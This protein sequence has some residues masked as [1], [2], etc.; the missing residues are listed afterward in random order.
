MSGPGRAPGYASLA[1]QRAGGK[2]GGFSAGG[3]V[4][5]ALISRCP[6]AVVADMCGVG[7]LS[8]VFSGAK[9]TVLT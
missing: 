2:G 5:G 9:L 8:E 4:Q 7:A 6:R 1:G 3:K